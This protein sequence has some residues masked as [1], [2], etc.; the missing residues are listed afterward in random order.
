MLLINQKHFFYTLQN[1]LAQFPNIQVAIYLLNPIQ[2]QHTSRFATKFKLTIKH[3]L[4]P[5]T[6]NYLKILGY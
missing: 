1:L 5:K 2:N 3:L 6:N 4:E